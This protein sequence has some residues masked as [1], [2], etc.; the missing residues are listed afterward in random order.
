MFSL[1]VTVAFTAVASLFSAQYARFV[2]G[3]RYSTTYSYSTLAQA[4]FTQK[5]SLKTHG[6]LRH[7]EEE[8]V[9]LAAT[10]AQLSRDWNDVDPY[11]GLP[12]NYLLTRYQSRML[13]S[14]TVSDESAQAAVH[15]LEQPDTQEV[16]THRISPGSTPSPPKVVVSKPAALPIPPVFPSVTSA[17]LVNPLAAFPLGMPFLPTAPAVSGISAPFLA[18]QQQLLAQNLQLM[19][20]ASMMQMQLAGN[21]MAAAAAAAAFGTMPVT[22]HTMAILGSTSQAGATSKKQ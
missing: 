15:S 20:M 17:G 3:S 10:E 12:Q 7:T 16:N 4:K 18:P 21:P 1:F 13:K 9:T 22:S 11:W 19:Q 14:K 5:S 8:R 2:P 6:R